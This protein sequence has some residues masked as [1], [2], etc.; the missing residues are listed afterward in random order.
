MSEGPRP[1][2]LT[3][4]AVFIVIGLAFLLEELGVWDVRLGYLLPL[5]IIGVGASLVLGST[6]GPR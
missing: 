6:R 3:A 5:V 4:G 1:A 2:R